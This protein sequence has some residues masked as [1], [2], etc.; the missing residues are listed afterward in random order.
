MTSDAAPMS[1]TPDPGER[2]TERQPVAAASTAGL[3]VWFPVSLIVLLW[4]FLAVMF[5]ADIGMFNG[6]LARA[7]V[8]LVVTLLFLGWWIFNRRLPR[9]D[10][11]LVLAAAVLS[12]VVTMLLSHRTLG[13]IPIL[14]GFPLL[15]TAW[16]AWLLVPRPRAGQRFWKYGLIAVLFLSTAGFTLLRMEGLKGDGGPDLRWRWTASAE[17]RYLAQKAAPAAAATTRPAALSLRPRDWPGFRGAERDAV[18]HGVSI[19]TDWEHAPPRQAWRRPIGP[20]WSSMAVVDGRVFTQEQRG[21]EEAVVCL[22]ADTGAEVWSHREPGRFWDSLSATGPRATPTFADNRIYA[23]TATGKLVCLDAAT[24]QKIWLRDTLAEAGTKLPDWG[25]SS[26][27]L[28][29]HDLVVVYAGGPADPKGPNGSLRA[30][31]A[32]SGELAWSAKVG[33]YSYSSAHLAT[34][35][36]RE[37]VLFI[38]STGLDAVDPTSGAALW[39]YSSPG[40]PARSCQP[41]PVDDSQLL[42]QLGL[43][44]PTD[45]LDVARSGDG[46]T[47]TKRWTSRNLKPSFN[48]FVVHDGYVYGFDGSMFACV[49]LKTGERK[50]KKGRYGTGQ[51]LLFADQPILLVISDAGEAVLVAAKPDAFEE[52]GRFQAVTGKT[53]NHPAVAQGK[54]YVRNAEEIACYELSALPS[55]ATTPGGLSSR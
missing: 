39:N 37:Q 3:R 44:A 33:Q 10:R 36:G 27:P 4:A 43:E 42:V 8:L 5:V 47:A 20:G 35:A 45:L 23:H 48:D 9:R 55:S 38:S 54:L 7:G 40:M 26:S 12:V 32:S 6:F 24:G 14:Y 29:A 11:V 19:A 1:A 17:D 28:V 41:L 31:H 30:Y 25:I 21:E 51:V 34:L 53:W 22:D 52:L 49:D 13:V 18:V 15:L 50:W 16:V 2:Q 46:F